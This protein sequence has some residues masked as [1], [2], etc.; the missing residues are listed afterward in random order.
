VCVEEHAGFLRVLET[1]PRNYFF[2]FLSSR[3]QGFL[4]AFSNC[5][6]GF[7]HLSKKQM[8]LHTNIIAIRTRLRSLALK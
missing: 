7:M 1:V 2:I 4:F 3:Y 6:D 5:I 8:K